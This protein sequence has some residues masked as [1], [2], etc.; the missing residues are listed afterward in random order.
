MKLIK[1]LF[2]IVVAFSS[3]NKLDL[4]PLDKISDTD[5]WND[6]ALIQLYVN[7][8]YNSLMH[9]FQQDLLSAA[10][11]DAFNIHDPGNFALIQK[12]ELTADNVTDVS[13]KIDYFDYAYGYIRTINIF[14]A[15]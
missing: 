4:T 15:R 8:C 12:G 1:Y 9:G 2:I 6:P 14:L 5:T 3:C 13:N 7:A 10:S 11:D